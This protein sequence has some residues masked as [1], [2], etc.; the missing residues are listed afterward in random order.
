MSPLVSK[1]FCKRL[2]FVGK[3]PCYNDSWRYMVET[4]ALVGPSKI[5]LLYAFMPGADRRNGAP[6]DRQPFT[7]GTSNGA[8]CVFQPYTFLLGYA[9]GAGVNAF[10]LNR[11]GYINEAWTVAARLDY[12]VAANLNFF[13]SF[14]WAERAS[15][16]HGWGYIRPAQK[17][18]V[19]RIVTTAG[20]GDDQVAWT[21]YV[22][23]KDNA[24]APSIPDPALGWEITGGLNW[25]LL[26]RLELGVLGAYWQPGKWF[27]YACIDR[28]VPNWDLPS[29]ATRWGANPNR[30][31][32]PVV[33]VQVS[34]TSNF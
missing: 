4:G 3:A 9:Y 34:V 25:K 29:K 22:N 16:G 11:D 20:V 8:Y 13:G 17:A 19:T 26:D 24:G 14:L 18:A 7:Q 1:A 33:G 23:Y 31:I 28:G 10:D 6:I 2:T 12:A 32:D 21:P 30:V 15:Q 5:S 27:N